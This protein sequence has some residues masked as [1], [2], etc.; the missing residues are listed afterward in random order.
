[1]SDIL[2][3]NNLFAEFLDDYFAECEEHLAVVRQELLALEPLTNRQADPSILDRLFR[4]FHSLKGLSGMVGVKEAEDLAHHQESYLRALREQ[5]VVLS[6][7]GF[8]AL[9]V[10]AKLLEEVIAAYRSQ[11]DIPNIE[12]A[13]AQLA[14]VLPEATPPSS[15]GTITPVELK[16]PEPASQQLVKAEKEGLQAWHFVFVPKSDLTERGINVNQIREDLQKLGKLTHSA[17]RLQPD[18]AIAFDFIVTTNQNP[19]TI[20]AGGDN[21][22]LT[23]RPYSLPRAG[24]RGDSQEA[25]GKGQ[26]ETQ[27]EEQEETISDVVGQTPGGEPSPELPG[28]PPVVSET[29]SPETPPL[30]EQ[31]PPRTRHLA[32][33]SNVVRV[34]LPKLDSL[35]HKVG[36][37]VISRARLEENLRYLSDKLQ[38]SDLRTMQ[39]INLVLER[40]MRDLRER[41]MR[42]RLVPIGEVFARMQFVVRDL[43]R[44][45]E[46]EVNLEVSGQETEIDK[47]VVERMMDPLLH[48]VRN[49]VSHGI[50]PPTE[51]HSAGK[52]ASG[53]IALR[54]STVGETVAIEI[55]DDGRGVNGQKVLEKAVQRGLLQE[56][57]KAN[58][59]DSI[60]ILEL[61]CS[62]GFSTRE[63]ADLT[64]GRGVGMAIVKNTVQELGGLL[65]L[66]TKPGLG[67]CFTIQLP[68]TLAI[69]DALIVKVGDQIFAIPQSSVV[70]VMELEPDKITALENNEIIFYR[71]H[72]LPI[73]RLERLFRYNL[74]RVLAGAKNNEIADSNPSNDCQVKKNERDDKSLLQKKR[75]NTI[76]VAIVGNNLNGLNACGIVVDKLVGLREI[77]VR[78]LTD[79]LVRVAGITGAT[80]LGDGRVVL[81]LDI[82]RLLAEAVKRPKPKGKG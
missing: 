27:P 38:A 67:T 8:D 54:A 5:Q 69:A 17:P 77:V 55:E 58:S 62:S 78:P 50:E 41:V 29:V 57:D 36:E 32:P 16:L 19:E 61:L 25:K 39:E 26:G 12:G 11:D 10:G 79:P 40:Q 15:Q 52:P 70:E 46:K 43:V 74:K 22:G 9:M 63:E 24:Q 49:A 34:E 64:S 31:P 14:S 56:Q 66:N 71:G 82:S 7:E 73:L 6:A 28:P 4:R 81:I 44:A 35:M 68:L 45:S 21:N 30:L 18:G 59:S 3:S 65:T 20:F 23:W 48:L 37:L 47:L 42:V 53:K 13:I 75:R 2:G 76:S 72:V 33:S 80:E 1:M 60:S 51:R